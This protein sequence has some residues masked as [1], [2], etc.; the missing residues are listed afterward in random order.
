MIKSVKA[1]LANAYHNTGARVAVL[2]ATAAAASPAMAQTSAWDQFFD[3][4][5][6]SG[7]AA[8]VI[9]GGLLI[10]GIAVAYKGPDLAK[11][12]IRKA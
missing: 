8:K 3:E 7:V 5:D 9:A 10:I 4:A 6:F 12:L 2:L 1:R 11:R